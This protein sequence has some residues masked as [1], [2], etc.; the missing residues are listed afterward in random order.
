[1]RTT[2]GAGVMITLKRSTDCRSGAEDGEHRALV[3]GTTVDV[4]L[5]HRL[6]KLWAKTKLG[7]LLSFIVHALAQGG[8][9]VN[10]EKEGEDLL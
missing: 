2:L 4:R 6:I 5:L 9:K 8:F 3:D 7:W 1:M 10:M